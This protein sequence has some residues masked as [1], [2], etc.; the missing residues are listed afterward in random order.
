MYSKGRIAG[1]VL[2]F[3]LIIIGTVSI[4]CSVD[5]VAGTSIVGN[6]TVSAIIINENGTPQK[7]LPVALVPVNYNA[8]KQNDSIL[9]IKGITDASGHVDLI[10]GSDSVYNLTSTDTLYRYK[11]LKKVKSSDTINSVNHQTIDLGK[12]QLQKPGVI[13]V[14]IDSA[15]YKLGNSIGITGTL[16]KIE[17]T[18]PGAYT[19]MAPAGVVSI[20]YSAASKDSAF[21]LTERKIDSVKVNSS[22]TVKVT[23]SKLLR[24]QK[25]DTITIR[26][27]I[28]IIDTLKS[29]DSI[30]T[31]DSFHF[32][33][34]LLIKDTIRTKDTVRTSDTVTK[35]IRTI[36]IIDTI[37]SSD[38]IRSVDTTIVDSAALMVLT[39][40]QISSTM[41]IDT[42]KTLDTLLTLHTTRVIAT[43]GVIS[44]TLYLDTVQIRTTLKFT[45]K[46]IIQTNK[47]IVD[48]IKVI[49]TAKTFDPTITGD[50]TVVRDTVLKTKNIDNLDSLVKADTLNTFDTIMRVDTI[51]LKSDSLLLKD[52][53]TVSDT[54]K[55]VKSTYVID[56]IA[57]FGSDTT[58]TKDTIPLTIYPDT[59]WIP[60]TYYDF[61]S[62]GSNPEFE[63]PH[64]S[65]VVLNMVAPELDSEMK[66]S[67]GSVVNLNKYSKYW[68]RDWNA[69]SASAKGDLTIP[70]YN[71]GTFVSIRTVTY[72]TA[73]KNIAIHDSLP[74]TR[75]PGNNGM[76]EYDNSSF[77]PLD[78][79]GF[80]NEA[81]SHNFSFT[82]EMS[83]SAQRSTNGS[84]AITGDD[85]I[86]VFVKNKL[87][88]DMGGIHE[89]TVGSCIFDDST[90]NSSGSGYDFKLFVAERHTTASNLRIQVKLLP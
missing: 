1:V 5:N 21:T 57:H 22:D 25:S 40:M 81:Q 53:I 48:T 6:P 30:K 43:N 88:I 80:G 49:Q 54:S 11:L 8:V 47:R 2:I 73:F 7:N 56:T 15:S 64:F 60:V 83:Y 86:W 17:V 70:T 33:D 68:F 26:D 79:K 76:Y 10:L 12:V 3:S 38:T 23:T 37:L 62:N 41:Y 78:G 13:V 82:M 27:T 51:V 52:T 66:P 67:L 31:Y 89:P 84:I 44:K 9:L 45:N 20:D 35:N 72:D 74:F 55:N 75:V 85:D 90:L 77:F 71:N 42:M 32:R 18:K 65:G 28:I 14:T 61:H 58:M 59:I 4:H 87:V 24:L 34:T 29:R 16:I 36:H 19:L 50:T 69:S 39:T 63:Q 46:T